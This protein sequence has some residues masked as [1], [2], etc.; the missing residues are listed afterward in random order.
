MLLPV[1]I[2]IALIGVI[3][4]L[5]ASESA[6][7]TNLGANEIVSTRADYLAQAGMQHALQ[8]V[9][10]RGC[11]PYT[12]LSNVPFDLDQYSANLSS[13]PGSTTAYTIAVEADSWIRSD[14][15]TKN[16]AADLNLHT[17]NE[18][19]GIERP[20]LRYDLS[21]ISANAS[22]LSATAWFYIAIG[23]AAGPIDIHQTSAD[24]NE[25]DVTWNSMN[26]NMH[27]AV[28]ATI[29]QQPGSGLWV[30][31]NLTSQVQAWINGQ[32]N[33][34]ITLNSTTDGVHGHYNS[35]ESANPPWLEVVVGTAPDAV[36]QI[37]A[38]GTLAS[39][40]SHNIQRDITLQQRPAFFSQVQL[41]SATGKDA[42]LNSFYN[43]RDYG[44]HEL[45][46]SSGSGST[47]EH[48]LLQFEM[49]SI[50]SGANILSARLELYHYVTTSTP[51][52]PGVE[53]HRLTR[54]WV[55]GTHG[56]T[57][58]AD[59]ATWDTWDGASNWTSSGGDYA[60]VPV[61]SSAISATTGDW[62]SWEIGELVKGWIDG[63][64]PNHGIILKGT[65]VIDVSFASKED[66]NAA[67]HPRLSIEYSCRCGQVCVAPRSSGRILMV[68]INPTTL[69]A[70][71]A[72]KQALFESWGYSVSIISDSANQASFDT[73]MSSVDVVFISE[74]VNAA[75]VGNKLV[76]ASIGV[77]NQ[78]G[79][80]NADLG[81]ATGAAWPVAGAI[82]VTDTS[83][84]IT[85]PFTSGALD[86]YNAAM[87]Q[88]TV[89]GSGAAGLQSL[90]DSGGS[91]ALAVLEGLDGTP[92][93]LQADRLELRRSYLEGEAMQIA[94][95]TD[96]GYYRSAAKLLRHVHRLGIVHNDLAKEP[97]W[98]VMPNGEPAILDFQMASFRPQ[99]GFLFRIMGREDIRHLLKH[100]R[101]YRPDL[102]S[103]REQDILNNPAVISRIWMQTGKRL[104]LFVTRRILG[105]EDRVDANE[106]S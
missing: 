50:P 47:R 29:P 61:D 52:D 15:P 30:P 46:I 65:G 45:Q 44:D 97:N 62:E 19:P 12:G 23:H 40:V 51:V 49:S 8:H 82:D 89:S 81:I 35:R 64:H 87:E 105:W 53:V 98:L 67:L 55:E 11:G 7:E 103:K 78:D 102:L 18:V 4:Y 37:K 56:G 5:V 14:Q 34:G 27:S 58:S 24:W 48:S 20:L 88:L 22:I 84:Y 96:S 36:A 63:S 77:V 16:N 33:Y 38:K 83:H 39:G 6:V 80:Y 41:N 101:T 2:A 79:D 75:Q 31:V 10:Q 76:D 43:L 106:R 73:A 99:R 1:A 70:D 93:L 66:V 13:S 60:P 91:S 94:R 68:V 59:G 25:T 21:P 90:A 71:D 42:M 26:A 69:V 86:I 28:L 100:K 85:A 92:S 9:A 32:P 95:P 72:Y 74:T 57:G 104:Y 54:S 17:R 3:A